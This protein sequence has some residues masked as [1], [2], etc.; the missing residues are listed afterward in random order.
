MTISEHRAYLLRYIGTNYFGTSQG[1]FRNIG[2]Y[3]F[4]THTGQNMDNFG[5]STSV[6]CNICEP[7]LT[8]SLSVIEIDEF[9]ADPRSRGT[10]IEDGRG[11][12]QALKQCKY[13]RGF[14]LSV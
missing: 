2:S 1:P 14:A 5:T 6:H 4:G 7:I 9:D 3:D 12:F 10:Q 8:K 11:L 13:W